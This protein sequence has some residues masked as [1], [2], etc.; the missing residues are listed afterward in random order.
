MHNHYEIKKDSPEFFRNRD[1]NS[2]EIQN[3]LDNQNFAILPTTPD[4]HN[5]ILFGLSSYEPSD[6]DFDS[7]AKTYIM[8]FGTLFLK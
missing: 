8:S 7:S 1:V 2:V 3:S 4:N 6:Y 5:L